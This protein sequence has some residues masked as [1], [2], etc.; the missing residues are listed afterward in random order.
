MMHGDPL[1]TVQGGVLLITIISDKMAVIIM[2]PRNL[3]AALM[4]L[5]HGQVRTLLIFEESIA[6]C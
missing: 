4:Y 6:I 1:A 5:G 3:Q 2:R